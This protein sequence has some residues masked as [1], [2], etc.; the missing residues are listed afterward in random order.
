[1]IRWNLA[2]LV[3]LSLFVSLG[4][5]A[6]ATPQLKEEIRQA[7]RLP[8]Q[9]GE[10][11]IICGAPLSED[12]VVLLVR[13]RRIPLVKGLEEDFLENAEKYFHE[14][15]PKGALF[16][17]SLDNSHGDWTWFIGGVIGLFLL[18]LGTISSVGSGES[19]VY[20]AKETDTRNTVFARGTDGQIGQV[21]IP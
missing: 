12:D 20:T 8:V 1:M 21:N 7:E 18:L 15:Q 6:F 4:S 2:L 19:A 3:C 13:G 10:R 16:S 14:L 5:V 11:C 9:K 17:E